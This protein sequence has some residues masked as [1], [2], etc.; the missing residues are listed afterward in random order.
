MSSPTIVSRKASGFEASLDL[1]DEAGDGAVLCSHGDV[2]LDLLDAL[3][4]RGTEFVTP[5]DWR[6][7][8]IC[9]LDAPDGEGR[10]ATAIV[11]P[12]PNDRG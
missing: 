12:P 1:L 3:V 4:R 6:K 11:E 8:S 2:I 7:G 10:I 5:P 9:I